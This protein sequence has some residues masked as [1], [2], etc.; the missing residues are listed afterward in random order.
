[1]TAAPTVIRRWEPALGRFLVYSTKTRR[2]EV[3]GSQKRVSDAREVSPE[4]GASTDALTAPMKIFLGL[5]RACDLNC[6]FCFARGGEYGSPMTAQTIQ[7][8]IRQAAQMGVFEV[9]LTGGE[10]TVHPDFFEIVASIGRLGMNVSLNTHGSYEPQLLRKLITSSV[11]DV[12]VSIDG[13][14]ELHDALRGA[15]TFQ[16]AVEATRRL[17][18]AG[19]RV[20]L[21]TMVFRDNRDVL[22]QIVALAEELG[23]PVRF[24]PMRP[25]GR[26][27]RPAFARAHVFSVEEW[28]RI[29]DDLA[30]RGLFQ[31]NVSCFSIED[32]EDFSRCM[33]PEAGLDEAHC[34]S[35]ITQMGIDPEGETYAGGRI[36]DVDKSLSVGSVRETPLGELWKRALEDVTRRVLPRFPRCAACD[37]VRTWQV[38]LGQL[39]PRAS[40]SRH[41]Y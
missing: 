26:A 33:G 29:E 30:G 6:P 28:H 11:D 20:R 16:R 8:V 23:V 34:S 21:N 14:E 10:P 38:W 32:L 41:L 25:I 5:T 40:R 18:A 31:K 24:C 36:D 27:R 9:R 13:P 17:K 2:L 3:T 12:R 35:W 4:E 19:K 7:Q 37:P 22:D 39:T 15:G 1:V